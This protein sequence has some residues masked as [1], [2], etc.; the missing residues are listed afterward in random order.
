MAQITLPQL[1]YVF[2]LSL[3]SDLHH[4]L[5]IVHMQKSGQTLRKTSGQFFFFLL[6]QQVWLSKVRAASLSL[7]RVLNEVSIPLWIRR[8]GFDIYAW[9]GVSNLS[10]KCTA[11][12]DW[13]RFC[14]CSAGGKGEGSA[15]SWLTGVGKGATVA[16]WV[17]LWNEWGRFTKN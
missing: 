15:L 8:W 12:I 9:L 1:H 5:K 13:G 16:L 11:D 3:L 14:R 17:Q 4:T 2:K 7:F 10:V 6:Y